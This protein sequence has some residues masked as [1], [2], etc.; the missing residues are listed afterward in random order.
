MDVGQLGTHRINND[1]N[2]N[3]QDPGLEIHIWV[4]IYTYEIWIVGCYALEQTGIDYSLCELFGR[5]GEAWIGLGQVGAK[6]TCKFL[7]KTSN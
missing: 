4:K 3:T 7:S 1:R 2:G 6:V 5:R